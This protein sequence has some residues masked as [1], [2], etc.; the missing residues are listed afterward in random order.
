VLDGRHVRQVLI[1]LLGNAIKFTSEGEVRL[2]I[3]MPSDSTL[4]FEVADTGAG[5]EPESLSEVYEAFTQTAAGAAAGGTGLGLTISR[6]LVEAMGG[7][8]GVESELGRGSR[9]HFSLPFVAAPDVGPRA[10]DFDAPPRFDARLAPGEDLMALVADDSTV[11]RRILARLLESA[12]ARVIQA[13]GGQE[14]LQLAREHRP[15]IV[16]MDVRMPDLN[17]L[18]AT[19]RLKADVAT[20]DIPVIVVT[21]S[22][23][24]DTRAAAREAG[25][26]DYLPKPVRAESLFAALH[27]HLGTRFVNGS[28]APP[29]GPARDLDPARR[30]SIAARLETAAGIGSVT[31]LELLVEELRAAGPAESAMAARVAELA[32]GFDFDGLRAVAADLAGQP[33]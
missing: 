29:A 12:G 33:Q 10:I 14:A 3:S 16:F 31:D 6:R 25:C 11:N 2:R 20:Q 24:G 28:D 5:I 26:I 18:E 7:T 19:R 15:D 17:G 4:G 1:N 22:A 30:A 13:A 32:A 8:L 27:L 21:A 9:F 23:F